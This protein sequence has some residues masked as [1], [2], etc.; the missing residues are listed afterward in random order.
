MQVNLPAK[1]L[2][3]LA[4]ATDTN[5]HAARA[6]FGDMLGNALAIVPYG[7]RNLTIQRV[8]GDPGLAGL[9]VPKNVGKGLL[10]DAEDSGF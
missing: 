6:K 7:D 5:S 4:H 9:R 3:P 8:D 1:F 10:D 2:Y